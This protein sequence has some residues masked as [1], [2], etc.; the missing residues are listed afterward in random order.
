[1]AIVQ[2]YPTAAAATIFGYADEFYRANVAGTGFA[3]GDVIRRT[4]QIDPTTGLETGVVNYYN[5]T[6]DAA[7][8][9]VPTG[10]AIDPLGAFR[11]VLA[12][13]T[14]TIDNTAAGIALTTI[15]ATANHAE[16]HVHDADIVLTIDGATAP[17]GGATPIGIRQADGQFFELESR[18]E[19]INFLGIRLSTG[20]AR[21]YVQYFRVFNGGNN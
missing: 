2:S 12:S 10:T 16:I 17:V 3:D 21:I 19:L 18:E 11:E 9:T 13:E 8:T 4:A 14:I 7:I 20:D 5:V 6:T 1:M 15:P